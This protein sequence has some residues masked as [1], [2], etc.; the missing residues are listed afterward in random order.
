M[1]GPVVI[2]SG[3]TGG[4]MFPALALADEIVRRGHQV[5]LVVDERGRRWVKGS[6]DVHVVAAARPGLGA[7]GRGLGV[8]QGLVQCLRLLRRWRPSVAACFGGYASFPPALAARLL[9]RPLVVHEQ[10]AVL[11]KANRAL[12]RL[13]QR[14]ALSFVRTEHAPPLSDRTLVTGNPLRSGFAAAPAVPDP[15]GRR[16]IL[17]LGGSQ[18][19]RVFSTVL[20]E[21]LALLPAE[22]RQRLAM[23]QQAR[24]EDLDRVRSRYAELGIQ[25]EIASFFDDMPKRLAVCDLVIARSGASTVAEVTACGRPALYVPYAHAADDH[26]YANAMRIAEAGGAVTLRELAASPETLADAIASLAD[27][28]ARLEEMSK[29]ARSAARPDATRALADLV[30]SVAEPRP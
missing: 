2:A 22:L 5:A 20:P 16:R 3:G 1:T 29:A 30:L 4:H 17:V 7:V 28:P 13:A 8:A 26:Q 12:A 24:P 18:G 21:A 25:A 27:D 11:G 19:A 9:G 23:V 15:D 10:N 6:Y 14:L